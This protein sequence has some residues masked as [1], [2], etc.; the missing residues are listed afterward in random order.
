MKAKIKVSPL[1][2]ELNRRV[3]M[4]EIWEGKSERILED[5]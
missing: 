5:V 1:Y 3:R 2:W 4:V